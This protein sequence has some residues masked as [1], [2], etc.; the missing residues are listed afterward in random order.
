MFDGYLRLL[1]GRDPPCGA[2]LL[3]MPCLT[4]GTIA[5]LPVPSLPDGIPA[6]VVIAIALAAL[7][8]FRRPASQVTR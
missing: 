3:R 6:L 1:R 8:Q 4:G 2:I 7:V 5:S